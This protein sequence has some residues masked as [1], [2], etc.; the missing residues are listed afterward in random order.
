M[1]LNDEI[2]GNI[3]CFLNNDYSHEM[4]YTDKN[5]GIFSLKTFI[6]FDIKNDCQTDSEIPYFE[7]ASIEQG[8]QIFKII[9]NNDDD[10]EFEPKFSR[11]LN[12]KSIDRSRP[13]FLAIYKTPRIVN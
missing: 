6:E 11:D 7:I 13:L 2:L 10:L 12:K 8:K 3:N 5:D 9:Y 1:M 4:V